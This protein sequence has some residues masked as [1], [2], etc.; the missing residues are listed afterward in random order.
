MDSPEILDRMRSDWDGRALE[1]AY[2]YVAFGRKHQA[3]DEF[4]ATAADTVRA[5]EA[6]VKRLD[7][8]VAP[9]VRRALEIGCGPGRLMRPLARNFGEIH[10]VDVSEEMIRMAAAKLERVPNAHVQVNS[11]ADLSAF[12]AEYFDF[13]YSYAVFQ[14]IPSREVVLQYLTEA[15]RVLKNGG[16]LRCQFNGLPA[17]D[18]ECNTWDGVRLS[19]QELSQFARIHD[20]QLLA[21]EGVGTQ[22]MWTTMRKQPEGWRTRLQSTGMVARIRGMANSQTG[23][24]VVPASGRFAGCTMW[25]EALPADCDLN[26]LAIS[27][28]GAP[29]M[30]SYLG[31]PVWDGVCQ[32]DVVLPQGTRTGMVRVDVA[33]LGK[34]LAPPAWLRVIPPGPLAPWVG[35]VED[36]VNMLAGRRVESGTVKMVLEDLAATDGFEVSVDGQAIPE[37]QWVPRS[38]FAMSY[39]LNFRLP[40]GMA[41]GLHRI[42]LRNGARAL[43]PVEIEVA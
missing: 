31:P 5:I 33:W 11:G 20:F 26:H 43:P 38:A 32:L 14:H 18:R 22:Y 12:S 10:G 13:V 24:P 40:E 3:E 2:Y 21:L 8:A 7:P 9:E 16:V 27:F 37:I 29:G 39:E 15:R 42:L 30:P 23:E 17:S 6:E 25:L 28:E 4:F 1:D 19:A 34:P 36:G 41:A 35:S